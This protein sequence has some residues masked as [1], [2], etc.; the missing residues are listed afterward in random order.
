MVR[1]AGKTEK[2]TGS[3]PNAVLLGS[4]ISDEV[5]AELKKKGWK[6]GRTL[7]DVVF[8]IPA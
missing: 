7:D 6:V 5:M 8:R 3:R 1:I 4:A 2:A